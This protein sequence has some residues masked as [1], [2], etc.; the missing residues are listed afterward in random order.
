MF[1]LSFD[2]L[3]IRVNKLLKKKAFRWSL[4]WKRNISARLDSCQECLISCEW[5][6]YFSIDYLQ[7]F[8]PSIT[9]REL[10]GCCIMDNFGQVYSSLIEQRSNRRTIMEINNRFIAVRHFNKR[11][12]CH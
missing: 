8:V 11:N 2:F 5:F 6:K 7:E 10:F 4:W 3:P 9:Y 1:Q 12:G